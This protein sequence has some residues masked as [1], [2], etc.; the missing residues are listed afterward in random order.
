MQRLVRCLVIRGDLTRIDAYLLEKGIEPTVGI[1]LLKQAILGVSQTRELELESRS[2]YQKHRHLSDHFRVV[3]KEAEFF[4]Y[5]RN[6]MVGHIKA[7]LVEKTLEWK[8]ETVVMLSKDSD[9]MQTYLLNFFV[10]ETA[11]NTYVDG[12]GKHKAFES[13]TDLG[14]PPDFQRLMQSLT[15]TVQGCVK[16]LTELE[17]VLRIEVPVPAFDPSD[18]TPWMKAGQT[19]F[20]FIKK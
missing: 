12:D 4:Q 18:M 14:Y 15:R 19:D 8:P 10:L 11:I 5:L 6:K 3:S 17:A 16:F 9:L 20:N 7:D 2:L 13:E 1:L